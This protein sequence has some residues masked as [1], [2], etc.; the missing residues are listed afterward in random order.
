M[1]LLVLLVVYSQ[2]FRRLSAGYLYSCLTH[3]IEEYAGMWNPFLL[4]VFNTMPNHWVFLCGVQSWVSPRVSG[5]GTSIPCVSHKTYMRSTRV[6]QPCVLQS[7]CTLL[8]PKT[9]ATESRP[10]LLA[11]DALIVQVNNLLTPPSMNNNVFGVRSLR[12]L[13]AQWRSEAVGFLWSTACLFR[14]SHACF[15]FIYAAVLSYVYLLLS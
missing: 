1:S 9:M 12:E 6:S 2:Y 15:T 10:F 8:S 5:R 13:L 7:F 3:T 4:I 14:C 11:N